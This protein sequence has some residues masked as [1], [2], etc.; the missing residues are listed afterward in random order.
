M[1]LLDCSSAVKYV[2]FQ[3]N[4]CIRKRI[5]RQKFAY[6]DIHYG[7]RKIF[8]NT[9]NN[10]KVQRIHNPLRSFD[11]CPYFGQN[12][13]GSEFNFFGPI[14]WKLPVFVRISLKH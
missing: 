13:T 14:D 6:F 10:L 8:H 4:V 11:L 5:C 2:A 7:V 1:M 3:A 12:L 9:L